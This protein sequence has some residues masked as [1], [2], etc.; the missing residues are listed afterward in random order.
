MNLKNYEENNN[1]KLTRTTLRSLSDWVIYWFTAPSLNYTIV[2]FTKYRKPDLEKAKSLSSELEQAEAELRAADTIYEME[3]TKKEIR[4]LEKS[5]KFYKEDWY[6][7]QP[8]KVKVMEDVREK[9]YQLI[10][11]SIESEVYQVVKSTWLEASEYFGEWN[12][13]NPAPQGIEYTE[14]VIK[15]IL[16]KTVKQQVICQDWTWEFT[17]KKK[18]E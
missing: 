10:M 11:E 14:E 7:F 2:S 4:R 3:S 13:D 18:G 12:P 8:F 6:F 15:D 1:N 17:G 9:F 16:W 5:I